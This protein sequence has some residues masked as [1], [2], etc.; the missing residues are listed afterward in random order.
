MT[1]ERLY[2]LIIGLVACALLLVL[3]IFSKRIDPTIMAMVL[4]ALGGVLM[5]LRSP[6]NTPYPKPSPEKTDAN[7]APPAP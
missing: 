6:Q 4:P 3:G 7:P 5:M 1:R 2:S